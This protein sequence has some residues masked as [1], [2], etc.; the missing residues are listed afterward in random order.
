[1]R[2][3]LIIAGIIIILILGKMFLFAKPDLEKEK[4]GGGGGPK[5]GKAGA[6]QAIPVSV[7]L[8]KLEKID[9]VVFSSGTVLPN[10]EVDMKAEASGRLVKL[11][12]NEGSFVTKG[13]L[14]AKIKDTDLKA[15]LQKL[16]YNEILAK[17]IEVR[18][19]KLLDINAISKE[20]YEISSNNIKTIGA[21][22]DLINAQ[23]EK[24]VILAPFTGKI[25]L[26]NISEGAYL[27]PGTSVAT[28]VQIDPVKIDFAV[29][30]K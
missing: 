23:L 29:P 30:E 22:K 26:K 18:Q 11:N 28:L 7:Y 2:T 15:Q 4:G 5:G 14:I 16:E 6:A 27:A 20:E 9:N 13:Q 1:M 19:K 17:Q 10:E 24:T 3:I 25:G 12:I 8:A 21:D